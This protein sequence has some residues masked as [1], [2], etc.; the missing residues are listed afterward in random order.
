MKTEEAI[1]RVYQRKLMDFDNDAREWFYQRQFPIEKMTAPV[2]FDARA[3]SRVIGEM[4]VD[5]ARRT[6]SVAGP[7]RGDARAEYGRLARLTAGRC[8]LQAAVGDLAYAAQM[9]REASSHYQAAM[10]CGAK[11]T[12]LAQGY[13]AAI[14]SGERV[15]VSELAPAVERGGT[16]HWHY[17]LGTAYYFEGNHEGALREFDSAARLPQTEEFRMQR[18]R[19]MSLT[20]LGRHQ[21]A[22]D[23]AARL[24]QLAADTDQR[25]TAR[26]VMDE[27]RR[28]RERAAQ[29]TEPYHKL[30]LRRLTKL[31]G[32][33]VR[34]DCMG[35]R[36]RFWV[37]SGGTTR[38]LLIAD[39]GEVITGESNNPGLEFSCGPQQRRV[40]L[41]YQEQADTATDTIGRIRYMEFPK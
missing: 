8:E 18:L 14:Q 32:V 20:Q 9:M 22:E 28:E 34:V 23:A 16:G 13:E 19:T 21:E 27:V 30:I 1:A 24:Q 12:D 3:S 36:A 38:K 35:Q 7:A 41:G 6:V 5:I 37:Q 31:E 33:I 10:K 40:F 4:E 29:N 2:A 11:A 17:M 26:S 39:P 15:G 25:Q